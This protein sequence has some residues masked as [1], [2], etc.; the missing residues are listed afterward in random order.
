MVLHRFWK[1]NRIRSRPVAKCHVEGPYSPAIRRFG[2]QITRRTVDPLSARASEISCTVSGLWMHCDCVV[3]MI[4]CMYRSPS[5]QHRNSGPSTV[6]PPGRAP[7][8][9][10]RAIDP[11]PPKALESSTVGLHRFWNANRLRGR[12]VA[13]CHVEGPYSPAIR[14]FG[15]QITRRT[16]DPPYAK[17]SEIGCTAAG[18][19]QHATVWSA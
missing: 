18:R 17:A 5:G 6:Y 14:R 1:A 12:P 7:A 8:R 9:V 19:W 4:S 13:K 15:T 3:S 11:R 2:T 10:R 16:G